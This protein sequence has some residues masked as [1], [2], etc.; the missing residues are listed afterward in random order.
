MGLRLGWPPHR[1]CHTLLIGA[2]VG[3]LCGIAAYPLRYLFEKIMRT[4]Y[5]PYIPRF[6]KMIISG[7]IGVWLH[8]LIDGLCH[9]DLQIFWP[10]TDWTLT[11]W[12]IIKYIVTG[13][14]YRNHISQEELKTI[15]VAFFIAS[16]IVYIL[17]LLASKKDVAENKI[18]K[19]GR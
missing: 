7:I 12:G 11:L 8:V 13:N 1:K 17:V 16:V 19:E 3:A 18:N 6:W 14:I 10:N 2:V 15:C 4:L 9:G 5:I